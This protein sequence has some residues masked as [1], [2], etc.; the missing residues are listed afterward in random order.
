MRS[1]N[2]RDAFTALGATALAGIAATGFAKPET[3]TAAPKKAP[4]ITSEQRLVALCEEFIAVEFKVDAV[5]AACETFEQE[6]AAE[7]QLKAL[8]AEEKVILEKLEAIKATTLAGFIAKARAFAAWDR[9]DHLS[10][11][12]GDWDIIM[13]GSLIQELVDL[14]P[15]DNLSHLCSTL[16]SA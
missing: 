7:A 4:A 5:H 3:L 16:A 9:G 6:E 14:G 2:R 8:Y 11:D 1:I 15:R 13:L 12:S 10:K